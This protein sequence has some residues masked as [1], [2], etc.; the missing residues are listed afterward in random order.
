MIDR[1][2]RTLVTPLACLLMTAIVAVLVL[3]VGTLALW[4]Y[5]LFYQGFGP[6]VDLV[7]A[8]LCLSLMAWTIGFLVSDIRTR[9]RQNAL[10]QKT[11]PGIEYISSQ[12]WQQLYDLEHETRLKTDYTKVL[13]KFIGDDQ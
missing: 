8:A 4:V 12:L 13:D 1:Y 3:G 7:L 11:E 9:R 2:L 10:L 6:A 5:L